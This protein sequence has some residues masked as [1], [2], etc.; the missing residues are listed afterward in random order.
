MIKWRQ[1]KW[2]KFMHYIKYSSFLKDLIKIKRK[3]DA[4]EVCY[5][6]KYTFIV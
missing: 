1:K 4:F 2:N 3:I 5:K 6:K